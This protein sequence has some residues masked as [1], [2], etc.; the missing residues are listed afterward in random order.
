MLTEDVVAALAFVAAAARCS[1]VYDDLVADGKAV[2]RGAGIDFDD[3]AAELMAHDPGCGHAVQTHRD[4]VHVGRAHGAVVDADLH[5]VG[6][7]KLRFRDVQKLAFAGFD[8]FSSVHFRLCCVNE[9]F[10]VLF[11]SNKF[12][13][14]WCSAVS[15]IPDCPGLC[16]LYFNLFPPKNTK[17]RQNMPVVFVHIHNFAYDIV[18]MHGGSAKIIP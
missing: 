6:R 13:Y 14:I 1:A 7:Q 9:S 4:D 10:H 3:C 11:S 17:A 8:D 5:I 12:F 15:M 16:A 2:F 18:K